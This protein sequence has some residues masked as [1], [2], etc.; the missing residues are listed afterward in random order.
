MSEVLPFKVV[1]SNGPSGRRLPPYTSR[2]VVGEVAALGI[3]SARLNERRE[4]SRTDIGT[5]GGGIVV[6]QWTPLALGPTSACAADP[7]TPEPGEGTGLP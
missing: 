5:D 6:R 1:R 7:L 4:L 3:D 2:R